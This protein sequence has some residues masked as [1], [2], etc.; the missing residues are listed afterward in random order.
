MSINLNHLELVHAIVQEA[1][2]SKAADRLMV[3]QPAVSKQLRQ[4]ERALGTPLFDRLPRG[5]RPTQAGLLLADYA[6]RIFALAA[7]AEERLAELRGLERGELRVGA[8]TT[9]A[10]YLLPPVFAAFRRAYPGVRLTVDI[11]NATDPERLSAGGL[12]VALSEGRA[13]PP[14]SRR[15]RS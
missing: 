7:E 12:D 10:V 13:T 2:V 9:I 1:S 8:S 11:A 3:S 4:M 15:R 6:G 14:T 5:V